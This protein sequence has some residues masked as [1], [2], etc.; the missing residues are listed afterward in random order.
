MM[1][2]SHATIGA[3]SGLGIGVAT[4]GVGRPETVVIFSLLGAGAGLLPDLDE[5]NSTVARAG[6]LATRTVS[7]VTKRIAGGHRQATHSL[8]GIAVIVGGLAGLS[9]VSRDVILVLGGLLAALAVRVGAR[10]VRLG[11]IKRIMLEVVVG[12]AVGFL[13][14]GVETWAVLSIVGAGMVGHSLAD[15][16]TDSGTPLLWPSKRRLALHLFHTGSRMETLVRFGL[17]GAFVAGVYAAIGPHVSLLGH[18]LAARF[19]PILDAIRRHGGVARD[20]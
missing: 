3:L 17:Y 2:R 14:V 11:H 13:L 6:G 10:V 20:G 7:A 8:L 1:G 9:L 15:D 5:E 18:E 19:D 16:L 4:A 12:A